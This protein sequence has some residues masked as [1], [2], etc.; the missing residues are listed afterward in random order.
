MLKLTNRNTTLCAETAAH[1]I[2]DSPDHT[3]DHELA[4]ININVSINI[5]ININITH[6]YRYDT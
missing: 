2:N 4:N 1:S 3:I 5:N 6:I